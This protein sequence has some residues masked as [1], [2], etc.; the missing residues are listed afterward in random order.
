M[1]SL[2][3]T[4]NN[5]IRVTIPTDGWGTQ[6]VFNITESP[7]GDGA[8][9][10]VNEK[11]LWPKKGSRVSMEEMELLAKLMEMEL[12]ESYSE[13]D[14]RNVCADGKEEKTIVSRGTSVLDVSI[15]PKKLYLKVKGE[16][17]PLFI[18]C[19]LLFT[20]DGGKSELI[21]IPYATSYSWSGNSVNVHEQFF[22]VKDSDRTVM[23]LMDND[24]I[25]RQ[26]FFGINAVLPEPYNKSATMTVV[27]LPVNPSPLF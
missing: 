20:P 15:E 7:S 25:G 26:A 8:D 22:K 6:S 19:N 27:M 4:D 2:I 5:G 23:C 13:E 10:L 14:E 9:I 12:L 1:K 24:P 17:H 11:G 21:K 16:I 18:T 3:F